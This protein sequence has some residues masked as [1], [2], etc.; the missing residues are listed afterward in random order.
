MNSSGFIGSFRLSPTPIA[1]NFALFYR[2][3]DEGLR[4]LEGIPG[5]VPIKAE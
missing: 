4:L 3:F 2:K 5:R 1:Q